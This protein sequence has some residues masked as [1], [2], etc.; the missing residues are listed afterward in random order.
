MRLINRNK[1]ERALVSSEQGSILKD[2]TKFSTVQIIVETIQGRN[3]VNHL[4]SEH[5]GVEK[6][7][8]RSISMVERNL[9]QWLC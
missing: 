9:V 1:L 2:V 7:L 6:L 4:F 8:K 3:G 5:C